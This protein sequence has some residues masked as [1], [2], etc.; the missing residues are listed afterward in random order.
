MSASHYYYFDGKAGQTAFSLSV[1]LS[2]AGQAVKRAAF[3]EIL[4]SR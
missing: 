3:A 4:D 1:T 2:S